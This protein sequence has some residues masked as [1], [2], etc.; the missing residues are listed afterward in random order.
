[1]T[2]EQEQMVLDNL[3][4]VT[5]VLKK[6]HIGKDAWEDLFQEG[7]C[8]LILAVNRFDASKGYA[9]STYACSYIEGV[10]LTYKNRKSEV[11]HGLKMPRQ[12]L[13]DYNKAKRYAEENN[14][15]IEKDKELITKETGLKLVTL[16]VTSLDKKVCNTERDNIFVGDMISDP[17]DCFESIE[18]DTLIQSVMKYLRLELSH[19]EY[20]IISIS[21]KYYVETGDKLKQHEIAKE[22]G[23]S[24]STVTRT[25]Q[26]SLKL[27]REA[28][29]I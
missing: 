24:Q 27:L 15:D 8:G 7:C 4:L 23:C 25:F 11:Y 14:L 16:G 21:M 6:L 18:V 17:K 19:L 12:Y 28:N 5:V 2:A 26:K 29:I 3:P 1:M 22:A 20:N 9:F 10:I 13:E